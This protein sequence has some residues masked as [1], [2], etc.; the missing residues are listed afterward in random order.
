MHSHHHPFF[1]SLPNIRR[2]V[3]RPDAPLPVF[4]FVYSAEGRFAQWVVADKTAFFP[5][6]LLRVPIYLS[7]LC[8]FDN[9]SAGL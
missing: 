6:L 2:N 9:T 1:H 3:F 7:A 4:N 5:L 8:N